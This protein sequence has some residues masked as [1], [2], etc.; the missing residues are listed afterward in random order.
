MNDP[1]VESPSLPTRTVRFRVN[2]HDV[3]TV[4]RDGALLAEV[5]REQLALT[6]T[7]LGCLGGDCGVCTVTLDGQ[8]VKSC[9]LLAASVEGRNVVTIE[10]V[11]AEGT[12]DPVQEALWSHDGFQC[13]F[14]LPGQV[15]AALDL[16]KTNPSPSDSDV[17]H[18]LRGNLC[19]CTGYQKMVEALQQLPPTNN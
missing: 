11:A 5:L 9:L 1:H 7:H 4:C 16:R 10:G 19:R 6:G 18:A 15:F 8:I 12:L 13:G 2:G 3:E 17:R 14:C